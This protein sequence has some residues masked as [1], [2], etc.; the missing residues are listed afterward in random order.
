[1]IPFLFM[2]LMLVHEFGHLIISYLIDP[3][4]IERWKIHIQFFTN[5]RLFVIYSFGEVRSNHIDMA[6]VYGSGYI[7]SSTLI[8]LLY[9]CKCNIA[10][11]FSINEL[12][13]IILDF[14]TNYGDTYFVYRY[15]NDI[16]IFSI[17]LAFVI[18]LNI[19]VISMTITQS[20]DKLK[21]IIN[22][23]NRIVI[24]DTL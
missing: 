4:I 8:A 6:L 12:Y 2:V 18:G 21:L 1:M 10:F 19:I 14:I 5:D 3:T 22:F 11:L 17:Y 24:N 23:R 7:F 13:H 16:V 15:A 9:L 20:I